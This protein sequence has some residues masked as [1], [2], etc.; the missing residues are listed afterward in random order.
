M[1]GFLYY[2]LMNFAIFSCFFLSPVGVYKYHSEFS[3]NSDLLL[4]LMSDVIESLS[5][6]VYVSCQCFD[7]IESQFRACYI[8]TLGNITCKLE[9]N[10]YPTSSYRDEDL[11]P[12][13]KRD[14]APVPPGEKDEDPDCLHCYQWEYIG[15]HGIIHRSDEL[16]TF[17]CFPEYIEMT[18]L[19]SVHVE[20]FFFNKQNYSFTIR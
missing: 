2:Y 13:L 4:I 9:N 6:N 18:T 1:Q 11:R 5:E 19:F 16:G 12:R 17:Q 20:T 10:V 14:M 7:C 15:L 8:I 3:N